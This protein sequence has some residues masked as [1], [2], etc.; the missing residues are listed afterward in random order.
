MFNSKFFVFRKKI[1][2]IIYKKIFV[3]LHTLQK[4]PIK[5]EIKTRQF[6]RIT[7]CNNLLDSGADCG[8]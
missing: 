3:F 7:C 5:K 8:I 1:N 2:Q 6:S 4:T